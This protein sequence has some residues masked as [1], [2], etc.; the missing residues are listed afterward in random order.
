[1]INKIVYSW[2]EVELSTE[3]KELIE[4]KPTEVKN[5]KMLTDYDFDD[6]YVGDKLGNVYLIKASDKGKL[7]GTKM[8]PYLTRDK[9]VEYVLTTK[10]KNKKHI[11][12]QRICADLWVPRPANSP[13]KYVNHK[14][15]D[16]GDNRMENL[17][18]VTHSE[19]IYHSWNVLRKDPN[20][21]KY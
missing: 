21:I 14:N 20:R 12:A 3:T 17:E 2:D 4:L 7:Y 8:M 11:Q 9:Y 19:N 1:M 16:R 5:L 6:R 13:A 15:G 10:Y 18:W